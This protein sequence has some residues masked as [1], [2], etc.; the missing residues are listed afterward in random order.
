[1][2]KGPEQ[3]ILQRGHTEGPET[4]ERMPASRD[5]QIKTTMRYYST[6]VRMATIIN[7]ETSVGGNV[8]K[9]KP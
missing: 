3:I 5:M 8:D 4:H 6:P 7:K 1:M 9:R 2:G